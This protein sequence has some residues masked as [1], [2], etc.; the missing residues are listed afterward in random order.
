MKVSLFRSSFAR[1]LLCAVRTGAQVPDFLKEAGWKLLGTREAERVPA[2]VPARVRVL[3]Q[4]GHVIFP[5]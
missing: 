4:V 1:E 2:L 3:G 5:R